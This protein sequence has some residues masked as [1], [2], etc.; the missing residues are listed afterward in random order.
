ML[1]RPLQDRLSAQSAK[2]LVA[3]ALRGAAVLALLVTLGAALPRPALAANALDCE[4]LPK[5]LQL[6]LQRHISMNHLN[7]E[8]RERAL[9]AYVKRLDPSKTLYLPPE[10]ATV[11]NRL[12]EHQ[13]KTP[14]ILC[15]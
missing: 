3:R 14:L 11:K 13:R 5:L 6:F 1:K 9:D 4:Y 8:L 15:V 2:S 10:A 7:D 12:R